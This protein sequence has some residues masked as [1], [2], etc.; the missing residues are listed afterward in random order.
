MVQGWKSELDVLYDEKKD[1]PKREE[2]EIL[3]KEIIDHY[4]NALLESHQG[5]YL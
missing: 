2:I 3:I 4:E 1:P 5:E